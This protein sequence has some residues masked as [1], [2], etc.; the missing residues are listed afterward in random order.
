[1]EVGV[2][3]RWQRDQGD[4]AFKSAAQVGVEF[5][6]LLGDYYRRKRQK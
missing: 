3:F 5:E 4:T 2:D 1:M 6:M